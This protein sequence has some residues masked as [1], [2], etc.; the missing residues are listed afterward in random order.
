MI[1]VRMQVLVLLEVKLLP[2]WCTVQEMQ[3]Y[4]VLV[5]IHGPHDGWSDNSCTYE[6]YMGY[7]KPVHRSVRGPIPGPILEP[8]P[9]PIL[10]ANPA[11]TRTRRAWHL[12]LALVT[13]LAM[14]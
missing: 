10:W 11:K 12:L 9:G 7:H 3:H 5:V 8:V 6:D 1:Q 13:L 4:H 2:I 14:W